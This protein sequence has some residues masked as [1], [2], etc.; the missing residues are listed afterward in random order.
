MP[1]FLRA[2]QSGS[3]SLWLFIPAAILLGALHGLEPGHSKTMMAA[4][5]V[6]IRGT[7]GQAVL[8]GLSAAISHSF[9]IWVLAATALHYGSQWDA[10]TV[11]PYL[12]LGSAVA[13]LALATW[14]YFRTR[15]ELGEASDH[16][17]DHAHSEL[18]V[19]DTGHGTLELSVFEEGVPPVFRLRA[20]KGTSLPEAA[21]VALETVR[22]DGARQT[23]QFTPKD[24]FLESRNDIPEPH[25]FDAVLT[26]A[27]GDSRHTCHVEFREDNHHH[28]EDDGSKEFQ[29]AHER[30]HAQGIAKRF[31]GRTVTTPQIVLFGVTGGLMPCPAAF[32]VLLV[33]LQLKRA[34]LGFAMVGAFSFGLAL[35]MVATGA[36]AAWSVRHAE[37]RFRGFGEA[38]R[39]APYVSCVLLV[40]LALYMAWHGWHGLHR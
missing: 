8:L 15:R 28:P 27:Q 6:A 7:I 25:E 30:E 26:F 10:E 38:M 34:T 13:I 3:T 29:D 31:G 4:F 37:K 39:R 20:T 16:H 40:L 21:A 33:C 14:M 1:D 19:L 32:T 17:H 22:A 5:I 36:L 35:T 9:I 2:L 12:Q 11:E 18:F 24:G 23:F